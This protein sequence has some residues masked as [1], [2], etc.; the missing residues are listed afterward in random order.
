MY[1]DCSPYEDGETYLAADVSIKCEGP[2]EWAPSVA[3][4]Y[5][6]VDPYIA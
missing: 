4:A 1:F 6:A 5:S 3:S 2:G